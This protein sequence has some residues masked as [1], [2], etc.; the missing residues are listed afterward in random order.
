MVDGVFNSNILNLTVTPKRKLT[1][2]QRK[3]LEKIKA[4]TRRRIREKKLQV[5]AKT[6]R[7]IR[8]A[9]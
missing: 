2:E 1:P 7:R 3:R 4:K 5:L 8:G 6:R 9:R